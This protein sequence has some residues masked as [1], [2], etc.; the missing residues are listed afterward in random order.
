MK[1]QIHGH[2]RMLGQLLMLYGNELA[3]GFDADGLLK[4]A[5]CSDESCRKL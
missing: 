1:Q 4:C 5:G 2:M 3:S